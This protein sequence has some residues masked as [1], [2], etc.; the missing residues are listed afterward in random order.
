MFHRNNPLQ[1][2]PI[3]PLF[4]VWPNSLLSG[5]EALQMVL[6]RVVLHQTSC[7]QNVYS[8][9][10]KNIVL[11]LPEKLYFFTFFAL[12]PVHYIFYDCPLRGSQ[13]WKIG[14]TL[15]PC[16]KPF[17]F[18]SWNAW[19]SPR[20]ICTI[21]RGCWHYFFTPTRCWQDCSTWTRT[22]TWPES[23]IRSLYAW[24]R[25]TTNAANNT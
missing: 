5:H 23:W 20:W 13:M 10:Q 24:S 16:L 7:L 8:C 22:W 25:Y 12:L 14:F 6:L 19:R 4:Y 1:R 2:K 21:Y 15:W 9:I 3:K 17:Y 11:C 18:T